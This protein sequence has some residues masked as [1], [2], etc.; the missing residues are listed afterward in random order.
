M[1]SR[2]TLILHSDLS[3][4]ARGHDGES[5]HASG[6]QRAHRITS[7]LEFL[8]K[9]NVTIRLLDFMIIDE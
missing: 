5:C 9:L 8:E 6:D 2:S 7:V 3:E 4:E 1:P